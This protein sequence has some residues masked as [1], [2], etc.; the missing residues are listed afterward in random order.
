MNYIFEQGTKNAAKFILLH[1]TGGD[2]YS[3]LELARFIDPDSSVLSFRGNIQE[4][5]MNRFFKRH[6]LNQFDLK[7]LEEETDNLFQ[8]IEEISVEKNIPLEEWILLGYSNGANIA[9]HLLLEREHELSKGIFFHPMSLGVKNHSIDG[10][11]KTVWLS[12]GNEDPIV[13]KESFD[14]LAN[15]FESNGSLTYIYSSN[16][17]HELTMAELESAKAWVNN[18]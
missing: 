4:N 1:G 10:K 12:Y 2:E 7:N 15:A 9:A 3:L 14:E 17:G 5:G 18:L 13:S 16:Q 8:Q 6:G 11:D